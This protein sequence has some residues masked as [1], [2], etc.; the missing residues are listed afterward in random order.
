MPAPDSLEERA[1][2]RLGETL[3]RDFESV[4]IDVVARAF[5]AARRTAA[6]L[7]LDPVVRLR[8]IDSMTRDELQGTGPSDDVPT[9]PGQVA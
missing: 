2:A 7:D 9:P 1:V 6:A 5:N 4:P 8:V 3:L